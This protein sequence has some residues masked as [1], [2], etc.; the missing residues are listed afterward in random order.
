MFYEYDD[1]ELIQ[2]IKR[3]DE[4]AHN[5]L[6]EK[7]YT[8]SCGIAYNLAN[9]SGLRDCSPDEF[10]LDYFSALRRAINSYL[11]GKGTFKG[12]LTLLLKREYKHTILRKLKEQKNEIVELDGFTGESSRLVDIVYDRNE[13]TPDMYANMCDLSMSLRGKSFSERDPVIQTIFLMK[14]FGNSLRNIAKT[15]GMDVSR[16]RRILEEFKEENL[17]EIFLDLK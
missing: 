17:A 8:L 10:L 11:P 5:L 15:V 16:V 9:S 3:G 2:R 13:I 6:A 12:Y 4:D 7:Y 14:L 1:Y